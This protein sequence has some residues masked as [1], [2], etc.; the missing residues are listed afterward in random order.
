MGEEFQ[1][2]P[3]GCLILA[4]ERKTFSILSGGDAKN[5]CL[6]QIC[7]DEVESLEALV[8][9]G[10]AEALEAMTLVHRKG[11]VFWLSI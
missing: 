3:G 7:E 11:G 4:H 9:P 6:L 5:V 8:A 10:A 1:I 2:V